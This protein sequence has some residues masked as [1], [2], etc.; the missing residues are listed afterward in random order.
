MTTGHLLGLERIDDYR[1]RLPQSF[2]PGM[3][4]PGIVFAD[5]G[6][7][8]QEGMQEALKQVANVA[9][10]P[11]IVKAS[12][13]M[14]DMHWGYGFPVGGVAA[15]RIDDGVV[16]PGGVGFDINCGV[17]LLRTSLGVEEVRPHLEALVSALFTHVPVGL[18]AGSKIHV[19]RRE[20]ESVLTLGAQWAVGEGLGVPDD[21]EVTEENGALPEADP[22]AVGERPRERGANQLGSLGAGNHFLEVQ[23][24]EEVFDDRAAQT[25]GIE[26]GNVTVL[27][28][29]GSRGFGHQ[30]CEDALKQM[31][32][33]S[34]RYGIH[35]PD[36]QLASVPVR[37]PE[38]EAYLGAM[39]CAANFAW[40]NRQIIA[41][42][43]R[44]AFQDVFGR[45]WQELGLWQ[46]YDVSH[47]MAKIEDHVID[48]ETVFLCVHRKGATRSFPAQDPRVPQRY[49]EIGQPVLIP[50]DMGRASYL[51][52]GGPHALERSF[53]S[54]CH[55]AGRS[56]SRHAAKRLLRGHD[57]QK[58][59]EEQGVI[60]RAKARGLLAEEAPVAYK[61]VERVVAVAERAGLSTRVARMRPL[62]VVKG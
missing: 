50:G 40:A 37:S 61:D 34:S 15:T 23:A 21:L 39:R 26:R 43:V 35:L 17:R 45:P 52:V 3:L 29:C 16:S 14:P 56:H 5:E 22:E 49:R 41:H 47:N 31:G 6:L 27:I 60:V 19:G 1:W 12:L 62:G 8:G 2:Q 59:L 30:V 7:L 33:A 42:Q 38:G 48:A 24:V 9:C 54:T 51:A 10:L 44:E 55:G 32:P 36:R 18:G 28:H 11:G 58:E 46:V 20:L 13:A 53:G 57:V 4:V 25:M